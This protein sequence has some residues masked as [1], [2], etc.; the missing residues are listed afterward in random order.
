MLGRKWA[1]RVQRAT[2]LV[3]L[4]SSTAWAQG[5]S[6]SNADPAQIRTAQERFEAASR[7]YDD[8]RFAEA[9]SAFRESYGVVASPNSS[10]MV[11][12]CLVKL[13]RVVE[14]VH[15]FETT[16]EIAG[17]IPEQQTKYEKTAAAARRELNAL[18]DR[19]G[20]V[21]I[22]VT[23]ASAAVHVSIDG[24]PIADGELGRPVVVATGKHTIA[25]SSQGASA[26]RAV[27][28]APRADEHVTLDLSQRLPSAEAP[29]P[30][31]SAAS[32]TS[33]PPLRTWA[34]VAGGI[35]AAGLVTFGVFGILNNAK[36]GSLKDDCKNQLCPASRADDI[37]TGRMYQT[38]ANV[39]LGV[40]IVGLGAGVALYVLSG[41][42]ST[43]A[44]AA[45]HAP[46]L[47]LAPFAL[48][49]RF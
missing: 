31:A 13:D 44:R 2:W 9:L 40:A 47:A 22:E 39:G 34:Y 14:A 37:D 25:A 36:Y 6:V 24:E 18:S 10:L 49:G 23:G 30:A 8:G 27:D 48:Q 26:E 1:A 33:S 21:S 15:Q 5:A 20:R 46:G 42:S 3:L 32:A 35:G 4:C 19:V 43:P 41:R 12:R 38:T 29:H 17:S 16:I 7:L 11:G 28:V 45:S